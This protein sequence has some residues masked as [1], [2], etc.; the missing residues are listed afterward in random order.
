MI[1]MWTFGSRCLIQAL[2][3]L[4]GIT[5]VFEHSA[6]GSKVIGQTNIVINIRT[7]FSAQNYLVSECLK[8]GTH[9]YLQIPSFLP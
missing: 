2:Q 9:G 6:T 4:K 1:E 7:V 5:A 8:R 3:N